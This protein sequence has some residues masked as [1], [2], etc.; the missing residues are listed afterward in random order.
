M[1]HFKAQGSL[2]VSTGHLCFEQ[3]H[4]IICVATMQTTLK[5]QLKKK[6]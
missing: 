3:I 1:E 4:S 6:N 5:K 2:Q